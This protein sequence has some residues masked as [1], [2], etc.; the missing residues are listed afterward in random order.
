MALHWVLESGG[1]MVY[2][3]LAHLESGSYH[4]LFFDHVSLRLMC[5]AKI[6]LLSRSKSG[7]KGIR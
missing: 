6:L 2:L 4:C 3:V 1:T 5:R 7:I